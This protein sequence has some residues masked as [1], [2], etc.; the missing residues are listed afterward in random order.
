MRNVVPQ[1]GDRD[2]STI[3]EL[4]ALIR[5]KSVSPTDAKKHSSR[6]SKIFVTQKISIGLA[7]KIFVSVVGYTLAFQSLLIYLI[8]E[9]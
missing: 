7:L 4:Q 8:A 6:I 5:H 2:L 3:R 1:G 9:T